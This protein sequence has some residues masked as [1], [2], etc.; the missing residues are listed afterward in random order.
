M[1][2]L[3]V[4]DSTRLAGGIQMNNEPSNV[5][6]TKLER[7][8]GCLNPKILL[9]AGFVFIWASVIVIGVG[10]YLQ[11]Q[12]PVYV[13][14][15]MQRAAETGVGGVGAAIGVVLAPVFVAIFCVLIGVVFT[16]GVILLQAISDSQRNLRILLT[17]AFSAGCLLGTLLGFG[18]A[19]ETMVE[20]NLVSAVG[21]LF[22]A[23]GL[24]IGAVALSW[25]YLDLAMFLEELMRI[26]HHADRT[27]K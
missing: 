12:A 2:K 26:E 10:E 13:E 27:H 21:Y 11:S 9:R 18:A 1:A 20:G 7:L 24:A 3:R 22:S 14:K 8:I 15:G 25:P 5:E 19:G 17:G 6:E 16:Y 23:V 4:E